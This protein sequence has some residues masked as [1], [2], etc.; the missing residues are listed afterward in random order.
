MEPRDRFESLYL[1]HAGAVRAYARRR[2]SA[3]QADD[4]VA[5]VFMSA[6]RRLDEVP[7]QAAPW[8]LGIARGVL[9]NQRRAEERS[10]ALL[11]RLTNERPVDPSSDVNEID[12]AVVAALGQLSYSDQELLLLVA[13][14]RLSNEELAEVLGLRRGTVAVRLHRARSRLRRALATQERQSKGV[15]GRSPEME[16]S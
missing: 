7:A 5:E 3:G 8:L 16:V 1:T 4:V 12:L 13:W 2:G 9:S 14:E 11:T 15:G 10:A 6:W